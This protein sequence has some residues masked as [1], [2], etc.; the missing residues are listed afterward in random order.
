MNKELDDIIVKLGDWSDNDTKQFDLFDL[1]GQAAQPALTIGA[2]GT[3]TI[4]LGD[5]SYDLSS[6]MNSGTYTYQQPIT[7]SNT[8][9]S[10]GQILST[11]TNGLNWSDI[12]NPGLK[13]NGNAEFDGDVKIKGKSITEMFDKI[14]ERLAILHPNE[15][16][17]EKWEELK[18]LSKRY[19]ELEKEIIEK[20][21]M[22]DILK[23]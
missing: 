12:P 1:N 13:V 19:K 11:G 16:L 3:D 10:Y 18:E 6:S 9:G 4:S 5:Y 21:K 20:E 2:V 22:W 15:K 14:E 23:R 17:E 8:T 7:I